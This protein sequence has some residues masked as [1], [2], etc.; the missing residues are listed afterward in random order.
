M[1]KLVHGFSDR[2]T[3]SQVGFNGSI[4]LQELLSDRRN[5][6]TSLK[7]K[8]ADEETGATFVVCAVVHCKEAFEMIDKCTKSVPLFLW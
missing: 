1:F 6:L 8:T 4:L 5:G 3:E 2:Y 7:Q